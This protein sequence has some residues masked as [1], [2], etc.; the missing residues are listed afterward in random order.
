MKAFVCINFDKK[1]SR[2]IFRNVIN[3]MLEYNITP[4]IEEKYRPQCIEFDSIVFD[5]IENLIH[6]CDIFI[7]VGGDGTI[8][9]YGK[10]AAKAWKM[11][12]GINTGR[13]GFMANLE[14]SELDKLALLNTGGF[15]ISK[16][17][18]MKITVNDKQYQALN[19]VVFSKGIQSKL[20][21]FS[22][23]KKGTIVSKIRADGL[24]IS[25]PTGSTAYSLSAGGP[26]IDP[27]L[28]CMEFTPLCAHTL[29]S[30][31]MIFDVSAPLTISYNSY[32]NSTVSVSVD[33]D[34]GIPISENDTVVIEK[35][36]YCLLL[37]D[38]DNNSFY[39]SIHN[40]LM[41]PLK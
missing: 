15:N 32:E 29:F 13:L 8:L 28:E 23:T 6:L 22:I 20:P 27:T 18:L 40:K 26:I 16:R 14:A 35:S 34:D 33:G 1:K 11:M 9:R 3:K 21:E 39:N 36:P 41:K 7:T 4:L 17:M 25:T 2:L 10:L 37:I 30:R 19:D 12:L 5:S 31:P 38:I 24:I